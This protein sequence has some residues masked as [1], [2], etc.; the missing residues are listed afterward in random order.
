MKL[1]LHISD[2]TWEGGA[3]EL[4]FKLGDIAKRADDGGV[5]RISVMDHVWQIGHIGPPEHEMLEAYTA[6]GLLAAK[7]ERVKLLTMVTAVVYRE[8]GLLAKAMTTLDVLSGGRAI[9]GIGAAWNAEESAGLGLLFPPIAERFERLEEAILI[10]RQMWSGDEG[11][12]RRQVLPAGPH[13]QLAAVAVPAA[14]ADPDRRLG[15]EEDAEAGGPLRRRVQHLRLRRPRGGPQARGAPRSTASTRAATTTRSRRPPRRASTSAS[16]ART[17]T[18]R[19]SRCTR[20]PRP[21]SA[22]R[23]AR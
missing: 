14:P 13:P 1:G 19:S 20:W 7:T 5:D 12:L 4:R 11:R 8:P 3:P 2:F 16:T 17:S 18:R 22:S 23:T 15:R 6:L 9:L 10:C 21:A